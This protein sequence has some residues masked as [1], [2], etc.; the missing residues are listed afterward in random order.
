MK[1]GR[2]LAILT[3]TV[4]LTVAL[5]PGQA[6]APVA[7]RDCGF[8]QANGKTYNIKADQIRCP[9]ARRYA[10]RYLESHQRPPGYS[11]RDYGRGTS[12]KFRCTKGA[13][14]LF[15]IRR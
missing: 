5:A 11:C 12:I 4:A 14:V 13:K 15:A 2:I 3:L 1:R 9:R 8:M 6:W 7:P 10:R